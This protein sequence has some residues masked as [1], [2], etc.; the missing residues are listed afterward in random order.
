MRSAIILAGGKSTRMGEDKGLKKLDNRALVKHVIDRVSPLVDEVLLVLGS[1][2]QKRAY[3][4]QL[5]DSVR[6]V[7]D[8]YVEHASI[9]GAISGFKVAKGEYALLT[10]CDM[11]FIS[12]KVVNLLFKKA[13]KHDGATFQWA[14][15]W[16]EPLLA[17]YHVKS[18]SIIAEKLYS[19]KEMRLRMILYSLPDVNM[20]PMDELRKIDN[21]MLSFF[22][23]DTGELYKK[24]EKL[25]KK[26]VV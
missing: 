18:A 25:I 2:E 24:A 10:G 20:I 14:N 26:G 19:N 7:I 8:E 4:R 9:I 21:D 5:G 11:P 1:E 3:S 12:P 6:Y 22:D 23:T 13:E 16:I 15:G 17:V